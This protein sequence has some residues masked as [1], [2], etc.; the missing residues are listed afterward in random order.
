METIRGW[1]ERCRKE[2]DDYRCPI[3]SQ[4]HLF[5]AGRGVIFLLLL[6]KC[7]AVSGEKCS[8]LVLLLLLLLLPRTQT[9]D[10]LFVPSVLLDV[11]I[12]RKDY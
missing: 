9:D 5:P 12:D 11:H 1:R 7:S 8:L 10:L 2:R 6:Q 3:L 4:L